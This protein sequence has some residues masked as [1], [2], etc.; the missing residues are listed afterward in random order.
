MLEHRGLGARLRAAGGGRTREQSSGGGFDKTKAD[1]EQLQQRG[2]D[3]GWT[4]SG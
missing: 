4:G 1:K 2:G 3:A